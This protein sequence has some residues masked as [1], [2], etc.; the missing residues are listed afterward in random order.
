MR[1]EEEVLQEIID[2]DGQDDNAAF[3]KFLEIAAI[4]IESDD[5]SVHI[6]GLMNAAALACK[7]GNYDLCLEMSDKA[8]VVD[9]EIWTEYLQEP[10]MYEMMKALSDSGAFD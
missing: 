10:H 9:E 4:G 6:M 2:L 5:D 7:K 8:R 1:T 3:E